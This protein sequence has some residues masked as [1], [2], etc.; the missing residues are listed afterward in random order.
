MRILFCGYRD[1]AHRIYSYVWTSSRSGSSPFKWIYARNKE[2]MS[3]AV[4]D[5]DFDLI[6][7][8]GWSWIVPKE[9]VEKNLIFCIHPSDLPE[10]AGGSPLQ[11]QILDGLT[12]TKCTLFRMR[13]ELDAGEIVDKEPM[14]LEGT[15]KDVLRE[16]TNVGVKLIERLMDAY[17]YIQY[18]P[19]NVTDVRKRL[20]PKQSKLAKSAVRNMNT[21]QLYNT[22]RARTDPYPNVFIED[23]LGKLYFTDVRFEPKD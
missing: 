4:Q 22:I 5:Y 1:W 10:Y 19:N 8:V 16:L 17:P 20:K 9:I 11:H 15:M 2:E 6:L 7:C 23:A 13:P 14:S 12:E 3:Q 18:S 21:K